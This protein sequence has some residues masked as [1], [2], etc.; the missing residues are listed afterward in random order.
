MTLFVFLRQYLTF[1]GLAPRQSI[2]AKE[3]TRLIDLLTNIGERGEEKTEKLPT[4]DACTS[5]FLSLCSTCPLKSIHRE[6]QALPPFDFFVKNWWFWN[7]SWLVVRQSF[8]KLHLEP[9]DGHS[10]VEHL[11]GLFFYVAYLYSRVAEPYLSDNLTVLGGGSV[12]LL[13]GNMLYWVEILSTFKWSKTQWL[14]ATFFG[15]RPSML[16]KLFSYLAPDSTVDYYIIKWLWSW[17][18]LNTDLFFF[19][20]KRAS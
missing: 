17:N 8:S 3:C 6:T 1:I 12:G 19:V 2:I 13:G 15:L 9:I 5:Y 20:S 11:S 14:N 7:S 18:R 16:S 10:H 4:C